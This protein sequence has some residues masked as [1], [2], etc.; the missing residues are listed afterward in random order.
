[1]AF[2]FVVVSV[3]VLV[4]VVIVLELASILAGVS[5]SGCKVVSKPF[6]KY[7]GWAPLVR[8][9]RSCQMCQT[10]TC[11]MIGSSVA[12]VERSLS[13]GKGLGCAC[14]VGTQGCAQPGHGQGWGR[15]AHIVPR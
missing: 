10:T 6:I 7:R 8:L 11:S 12:A 9:L 14:R 4:R 13:V 1:V 2:V 15:A 3:L 5:I